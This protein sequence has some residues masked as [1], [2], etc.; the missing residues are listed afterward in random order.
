MTKQIPRKFLLCPKCRSTE[1]SFT[2]TQILCQQCNANFAI[3]DNNR[4]LFVTPPQ[5]R[6]SF[7]AKLKE[8]LKQFPLLYSLLIHIVSPVCPTDY[9]KQKKLIKT[10]LKNNPEAFI[11][12]LGS[13]SS[14]ISTEVT[15][16]DYFLYKN[17]AMSCDITSLPIQESCIDMIFNIA[18]LEHTPEPEKVISEIFR[19]LK[20][21][22]MLYCIFPFMQGFHAAP[23]DFSRRTEAGLQLL[24]QDFETI[25]LSCTGGPTSGLLWIFEEWL[26]ILLSFGF[27]PLYNVIHLLAMVIFWPIKFLDFILIK[28][29]AAKNISSSFV[30]I[31]TKPHQN[32]N[33]QHDQVHTCRD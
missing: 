31:G 28:H 5:T 17:V 18:V 21:G 32:Q 33:D 2:R 10:A 3:K 14:N 12:N 27:I 6:H 19:T 4:Y 23:Y 8:Y 15:N 25:E 22:G 9:F 16:V 26:A 11:V 13:G 1:L 20:P 24:F 7:I 29:P 30:F